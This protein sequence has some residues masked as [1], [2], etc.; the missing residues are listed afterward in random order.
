MVNKMDVKNSQRLTFRL[1]TKDD[2][3]DLFDLDND[4]EVMRYITQGK[5]PPMEEVLN[6]FIPRFEAYTN[7]E[8]GWGLWKVDLETTGEFLGWIL[9]RPM[10]FYS[11]TPEFDNLEIGWRFKQLTWGKG[12]ATEAAT[13]VKDALA[14]LAH[15]KNTG[16][17]H[18]S[19]I[20]DTA[21]ADSI[22]IMKK[23]GM[24]HVKSYVH[25]SPTADIP[26][27]YYQLQL[28]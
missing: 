6:V 15:N 14:D 1:M 27:E 2:A 23:L 28:K 3:Q 12:Y 7:A 22:N 16:V 20:A 25:Q 4:P 26:A 5:T 19:A 11:D 17:T 8:Q 9:I 13:A 21:N 18:L 24:T 10:G